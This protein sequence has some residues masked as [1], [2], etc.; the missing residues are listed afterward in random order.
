MTSLVGQN[1]VDIHGNVK[2]QY[3]STLDNITVI[4]YNNGGIGF[5]T[6]T[7]T[8]GNYSLT[9]PKSSF[10]NTAN[11]IFEQDIDAF[12]KRHIKDTTCLK[13]NLFYTKVWRKLYKLDTIKNIAALSSLTIDQ[14]LTNIC[15]MIRFPPVI[16]DKNSVLPK[17]NDNNSGDFN[18]QID[19]INFIKCFLNN[20]PETTILIWG[21]SGYDEE[22][23][24]GLSLQRANYV[25]QK[26][27]ELGINPKRIII[28]GKG[29][30]KLLVNR[31]MIKKSEIKVRKSYFLDRNRRCNIRIESVEFKE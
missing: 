8:L 10:L 18:Y 15:E 30:S 26:L 28:E 21:H 5:N 25:K 14:T 13:F 22:N 2:D 11:M 1:T 20:N 31:K 12:K 7:D 24:S 19:S 3:G 23:K 16:F 29:D 6:K 4:Y 17:N 9:I 27:V